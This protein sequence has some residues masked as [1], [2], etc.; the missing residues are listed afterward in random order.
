[1]GSST[2]WMGSTPQIH[3]S[4]DHGN[5]FH[6]PAGN[7]QAASGPEYYDDDDIENEPPLLEGMCRGGEDTCACYALGWIPVAEALVG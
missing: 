7:M 2:D 1:M 4:M 3:H 5:S 6:T